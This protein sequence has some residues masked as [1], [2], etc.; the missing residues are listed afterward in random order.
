MG[1]WCCSSQG[2]G[3]LTGGSSG[4]L[5]YSWILGYSQIL[6]DIADTLGQSGYSW[7]LWK[8]VDILASP[9]HYE[10]IVVVTTLTY[11]INLQ[12]QVTEFS[13]LWPGVIFSWLIITILCSKVHSTEK[14]TVWSTVLYICA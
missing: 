13:F 4:Y 6:W 5:G 2:E 7:I 3:R 8:P 14:C 9:P 10:R 11:N 1:V 12:S